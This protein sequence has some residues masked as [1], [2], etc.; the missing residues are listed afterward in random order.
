MEYSGL[1]AQKYTKIA[2]CVKRKGD[3]YRGSHGF[4]E[5]YRF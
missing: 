5:I 4:G 3:K 1:A 2:G